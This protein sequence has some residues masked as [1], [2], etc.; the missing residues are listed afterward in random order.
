MLVGNVGSLAGLVVGLV[1]LW[2]NFVC[3]YFLSYL[4]AAVLLCLVDRPGFV[5]WLVVAL[6]QLVTW[7]NVYCV[8][9]LRYG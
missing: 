7:I 4:F 8:R 2:F 1:G 3:V 6:V 9:L 5:G